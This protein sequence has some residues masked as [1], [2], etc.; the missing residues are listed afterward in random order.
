VRSVA[1]RHGASIALG[2]SPLGG[3]R[4]E[5]RFP[6]AAASAMPTLP[7]AAPL[8]DPPSR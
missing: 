2:D 8:G 4:V 7:V 3:L 5:L 1:E 6:G